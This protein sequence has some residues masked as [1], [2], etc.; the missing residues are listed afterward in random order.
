M[1]FSICWKYKFP[2]FSHFCPRYLFS[3]IYS[4]MLSNSKNNHTGIWVDTGLDFSK[5]FRRTDICIILRPS[6]QEQDTYLF[7]QVLLSVLLGVIYLFFIY[8]YIYFSYIYLF[9]I[10]I[11]FSYIYIFHIYL[12]FIYIFIFHIYLFFIYIYLFFMWTCCFLPNLFLVF[13]SLLLLLSFI[14]TDWLPIIW[15]NYNSKIEGSFYLITIQWA[16]LLDSCLLTLKFSVQ[17]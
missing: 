9:F 16:V 11:Y 4:P 12:F 17:I 14:Y 10:Y 1:C 6:R 2:L 13:F 5:C 7:T 3:P 15:Q 8:I